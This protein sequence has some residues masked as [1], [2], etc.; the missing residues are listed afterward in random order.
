MTRHGKA[1]ATST[2][3]D[4]SSSR[5]FSSITV[6][7]TQ[8]SGDEQTE[9]TTFAGEAVRQIEALV[10]SFRN[11]KTKK[12][13]TI[14]RIGQILAD[15]STGSE[16]LKSDSLDGYVATL[17]GIEA[18]A[19]QSDRHGAYVSASALGK[20]K[21]VSGNGDRRSEEPVR[22]NPDVAQPNLD[23]FIQRLSEEQ[24]VEERGSAVDSDSR[25][26]G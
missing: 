25:D 4:S 5:D 13:Q 8:R 7:T 22:S 2:P 17:D 24:D 14:Y 12:A 21:D 16:Q 3:V 11:G 23:D 26:D 9:E 6:D 20:R 15:E 18:L 10:E 1:P 19:A